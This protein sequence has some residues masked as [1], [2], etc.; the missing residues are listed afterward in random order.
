MRCPICDNLKFR[1][2]FNLYD[3]RYGE[4]NLYSIKE[5]RECGHYCT[6]PRIRNDRISNLYGTFYPRKNI[7]LKSIVK[8]AQKES[9]KFSGF[10]RWLKGTNNQGQFYAKKD[11]FFLDIGCGSGASLIEAENLGANAFGLEADPNVE[12]ISKE[13]NLNI[14][15]G[16]LEESPFKD[17][18]FDLIVLNQVIE[19]IPEPDILLKKLIPKLTNNGVIIIS[20]PNVNSF[21]RFLFKERWIN[22]HVPYHMHHFKGKNFGRL[23]KK[24]GFQ[25]IKKNSIT[26]NI[27]SLMQIRNILKPIEIGEKNNQ[28]IS[29]DSSNKVNKTNKNI[30]NNLNIVL[31]TLIKILIFTPITI[32]NRFIDLFGLGDSLIFFIKVKN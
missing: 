29:H 20:F 8:E 32:L 12:K 18:K 6:F 27:W 14:F 2:V 15:Q 22:W 23:L 28:W 21:W 25:I 1:K 30:F 11:D 5:C 7:D 26:P 4:P 13:L 9:Y 3:D 24:C 19:H 17:I 10:F 16:N 31:K